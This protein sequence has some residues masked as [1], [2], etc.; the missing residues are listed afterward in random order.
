MDPVRPMPLARLAYET[1]GVSTSSIKIKNA[2]YSQM[3]GRRE[4]F[5]RRNRVRQNRR[6]WP[7]PALRVAVHP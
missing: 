3:G 6:A 1:D 5:E 4:L 2:N 7:S